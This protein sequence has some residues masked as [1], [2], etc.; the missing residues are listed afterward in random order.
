[1]K[2][3][4]RIHWTIAFALLAALAWAQQK[5]PA[6]MT[7]RE[8]FYGIVKRQTRPPAPPRPATPPRTEPAAAG[9]PLALRYSL[10]KLSGSRFEEV[11]AESIFRSGEHIRVSVSVNDSAYL[12]IVNQGTSG[13]W[14]VLFP[15]ARVAEGANFVAAETRHEI[16]SGSGAFR[17]NETPG[18]ERVFILA[19]RERIANLDDLIYSL[20]GRTVTAP[21]DQKGNPP[22]MQIAQNIAPIADSLIAGIRNAVQARDLIFE[23]V[24]TIA[25]AAK[26]HAVYVANT[27][28]QASGR[29]QAE[30]NL[31]HQ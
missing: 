14:K 20:R 24:D 15:N 13:T 5:A 19:S 1:M 6:Q 10:L 25:G 29:V 3:L 9:F 18:V 11:D 7:A 2:T 23:K 27:T 26:E 31:K 16:P 4:F 28:G 22:P 17:F 21:A 12:Y 8:V 30:L